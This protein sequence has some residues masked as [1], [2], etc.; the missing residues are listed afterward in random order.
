MTTKD[1]NDKTIFL[2]IDTNKAHY[3]LSKQATYIKYYFR[4]MS[5]QKYFSSVNL[6]S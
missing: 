3:N 5:I 1:I 2:L 6:F 4:N